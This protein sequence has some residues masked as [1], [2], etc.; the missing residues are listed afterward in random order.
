MKKDSFIGEWFLSDESICQTLID[1]FDNHP[2]KHPGFCGNTKKKSNVNKN[3]KQST[4]LSI[5][6]DI[7]IQE[8]FSTYL[9]Q[10]KEIIDK[11]KKEYPWCDEYS[12]WGILEQGQI[13]K[14]KPSEAFFAYHTE[15]GSSVW[16]ASARHLVYMTYLNTV[17]DGGE[18]EFFHQ[19]LKVKPEKGKTLIWP[20][21]WTHTHRGLP[22]P[23][24]TKYIITGWLS[25]TDSDGLPDQP[26]S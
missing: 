18:T 20:A 11:Y 21:D 4:D 9:K 25:Y 13:Q 15:R 14:Y 12:P 26:P 10:L 16:P 22:S 19:N 2:D 17:S 7:L 3:I 24:E 23:T 8:P 1:F 6:L 5:T